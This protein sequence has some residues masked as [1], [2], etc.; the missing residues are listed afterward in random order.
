MLS[1]VHM[2][3]L[4]SFLSDSQVW[5]G[6]QSQEIKVESLQRP[7][8]PALLAACLLCFGCSCK[9]NFSEPFS[10]ISILGRSKINRK[11]HHV[12]LQN[13]TVCWNQRG[14]KYW[15]VLY[16]SIIIV[17]VVISGAPC[18]WKILHRSQNWVLCFLVP[19]LRWSWCPWGMHSG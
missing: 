15:S 5:L 19:P 4:P 3:L 1:L 18:F 12:G 17:I 7:R 6:L 9:Q 2:L 14:H 8:A 13:A 16:Y 11:I 10:L